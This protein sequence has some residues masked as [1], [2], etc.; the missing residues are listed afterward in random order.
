M[1]QYKTLLKQEEDKVKFL[2]KQLQRE[3]TER[4]IGEV[5]LSEIKPS[6]V[7]TGAGAAVVTAILLH[8]RV[9][10]HGGP[11]SGAP[12]S[13][14]YAL[15]KLLPPHITDGCWEPRCRPV[16]NRISRRLPPAAAD[17]RPTTLHG[18]S[19]CYVH[20]YVP[21]HKY[22]LSLLENTLFIFNR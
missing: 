3:T 4:H 1:F 17:R 11:L 21:N 22:S 14:R 10:S 13:L 19:V 12:I 8:R 15:D 2:E 9:S 20:R 5:K 6:S 16:R 7:A 18:D